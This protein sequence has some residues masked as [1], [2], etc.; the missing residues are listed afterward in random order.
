MVIETLVQCGSEWVQAGEGNFWWYAVN[1][2]WAGLTIAQL[3]PYFGNPNQPMCFHVR[4]YPANKDICDAP[5]FKKAKT[6]A[7]LYYETIIAVG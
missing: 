4:D 2:A 3:C 6:L 7:G 5:T 1:G